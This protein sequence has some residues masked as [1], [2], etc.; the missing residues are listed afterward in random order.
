MNTS[1][2]PEAYCAE[3]NCDWKGEVPV[4]ARCPKCRSSQVR[5]VQEKDTCERRPS[6]DV[7]L[8]Q[9]DGLLEVM[10]QISYS[11]QAPGHVNYMCKRAIAKTAESAI[12]KFGGAA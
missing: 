1:T 7:L 2:Q 6:Y 10:H 5:R 8:S 3:M 12:A 9:R 4:I 11:H